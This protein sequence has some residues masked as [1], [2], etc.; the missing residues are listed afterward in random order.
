MSFL[1]TRSFQEGSQDSAGSCEPE[2]D[3]AT[4]RCCITEE[5]STGAQESQTGG[6]GSKKKQDE[7]TK[8]V[9]KLEPCE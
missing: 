4:V 5:R 9:K 6:M 2:R 1:P 7:Q 3:G 8:R